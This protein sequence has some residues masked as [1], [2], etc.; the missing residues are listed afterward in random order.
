M[1]LG[2]TYRPNASDVLGV[3]HLR[4]Y[5]LIHLFLGTLDR[6]FKGIW[7][8]L[9]EPVGSKDSKLQDFR[10]DVLMEPAAGR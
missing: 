6:Y 2:H 10:S 4:L 9:M 8:V 7:T 3:F 1:Q 5:E